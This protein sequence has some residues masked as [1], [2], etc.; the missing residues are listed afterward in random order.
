T[1]GGL[2]AVGAGLGVLSRIPLT[3]L[4]RGIWLNVAMFTGVLAL[5]AVFL[6][7]GEALFRLPLLGWAVTT[8][9][10]ESAAFLVGRGITASTFAALTV[11]ATPWPHLLKALRA[12]RVPAVL[13]VILSMSYRYIFLLLQTA[14]DMFEARRSRQIGRLSGQ[15]KRRMLVAEAGA[16]LSKSLHLADEVFLA[17]Q[18]RGYRGEQHALLEFRMAPRDWAA[19]AALSAVAGIALRFHP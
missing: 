6:V 12:L 7:P 18:S 9:G 4:A 17:M 13:V 11:L 8:Q 19:L 5:P 1:L 2:L 15:E 10:T 16:L 3:I 14:L